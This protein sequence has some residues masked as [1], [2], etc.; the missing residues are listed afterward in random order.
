MLIA[1]CII[2]VFKAENFLQIELDGWHPVLTGLSNTDELLVTNV[3]K[4]Y[5]LLI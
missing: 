5:I 4:C 3:K 1:F 2:Y